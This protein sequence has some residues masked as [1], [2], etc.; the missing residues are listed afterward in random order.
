MAAEGMPTESARSIFATQLAAARVRLDAQLGEARRPQVAAILDDGGRLARARFRSM[1]EGREG[2][3]Q[4]AEGDRPEGDDLGPRSG[5]VAG[6]GFDDP[7]HSGT[8][9]VPRLQRRLARVLDDERA[10]AF[11]RAAEADGRGHDA[12]RVRDLSDQSI[13]HEWL[14][15]LA[16]SS[17]HTLELDVYV[18]AVRLRLGAA[19]AGAACCRAC[20]RAGAVDAAHALCCAPGASTRGLN[21]LRDCLLGLARDGDPHAVAEA[22]GL[23]P[24]APG[25]RPAD[26]LT[27]AA[28]GAGLVALDVGIASPDSQLAT[29]QGDALE[30]MRLRKLGRYAAHA[31]DMREANLAYEPLPWGCWGREHENTTTVLV[32]LCRRAARRRGD[33][34]WRS[35]L[36]GFR[37]DVGAIL[38]RRA[39]A[40]WRVCTLPH[41]PGPPRA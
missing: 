6:V 17:R 39:S 30:A 34:S 37:A 10:D 35:V 41:S 1:V 36:R 38:A 23:L 31:E 7:E 21:E 22:L 2:E 16:L 3:S 27:N 20:G 15:S 19:A 32:A 11:A 26:V 29:A 13:N 25:L 33:A 28:G 12:R 8:R 4:S 5:V 18:D 40:M 24:A 14:S 9:C